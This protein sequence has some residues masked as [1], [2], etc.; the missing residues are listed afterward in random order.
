M[1]QIHIYLL[2]YKF[3]HTRAHTHI[4]TYTIKIFMRMLVFELIALVRWVWTFFSLYGGHSVG[5]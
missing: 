3:I 5:F 2:G 1:A 4:H